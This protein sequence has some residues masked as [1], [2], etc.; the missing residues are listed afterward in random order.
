VHILVILP[1]KGRSKDSMY[2]LGPGGPP[3]STT[4][5][6]LFIHAGLRTSIS[7]SS[8]NSPSASAMG[9]TIAPEKLKN[10]YVFIS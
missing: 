5:N 10:K 2:Y 4:P 6:R 3:S 7:S 8:G 1:P 9:G